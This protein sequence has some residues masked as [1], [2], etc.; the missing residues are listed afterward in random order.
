MVN[1]QQERE[2][3]I[4]ADR[5]LA[6]GKRRI[7]EQIVL[8]QNLTRCGHDTTEAKKLL[9]NFEDTLEIW[10]T[11]RGLILDAIARG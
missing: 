10:H 9:Q 1:I 2:Y 8:I 3:L 5:H 11:H 4:L 7:A 6:E